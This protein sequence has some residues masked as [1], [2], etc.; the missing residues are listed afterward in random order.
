MVE[1]ILGWYGV[2]RDLRAVNL[3]YF[4]AAGASDDA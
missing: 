1:K 2:T 4:N 3:R